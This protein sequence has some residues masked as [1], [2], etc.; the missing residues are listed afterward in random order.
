MLKKIHEM[1]PLEKLIRERLTKQ[2][3]AGR[4]FTDHLICK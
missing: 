1:D 2:I 4:I 3:E